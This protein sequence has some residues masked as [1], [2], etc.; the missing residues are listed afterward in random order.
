MKNLFGLRQN[1]VSYCCNILARPGDN[2]KMP[3]YR[4]S[5]IGISPPLPPI[6][7]I[8]YYSY[9]HKSFNFNIIQYFI[10][11]SQNRRSMNAILVG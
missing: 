4:P 9:N 6:V 7:I 2:A 11:A 3:L 10:A 1:R 8:Y 5:R